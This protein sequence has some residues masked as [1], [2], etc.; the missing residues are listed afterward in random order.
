[1]ALVTK[2]LTYRQS[3]WFIPSL[4]L[5]V[6]KSE[7]S[8]STSSTLPLAVRICHIDFRSLESSMPIFLANWTPRIIG[9]A[10]VSRSTTLGVCSPTW[11]ANSVLSIMVTL[12]VMEVLSLGTTFENEWKN[13]WRKWLSKCLCWVTNPQVNCF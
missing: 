11:I 13:L 12:V 7:L 6:I 3:S 8:P 4:K 9:W 10:L 2:H 5:S 1:M